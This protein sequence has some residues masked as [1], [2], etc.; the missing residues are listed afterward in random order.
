MDL[1]LRRA[2]RESYEEMRTR[3]VA[4]TSAYLTECLRHPEWAVHI[5]MIPADSDRFPPSFTMSFWDPLLLD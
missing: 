5:P 4:E 1:R 3:M 2:R